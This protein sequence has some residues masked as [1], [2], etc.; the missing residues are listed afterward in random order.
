MSE[1]VVLVGP[2]ETG[3]GEAL[4]AEGFA[5]SRTEIGNRPGLEE[6]GIH[7]A[8]V[9][10]LTDVDQATSITVATD[11]NPDV[12]V[13]IYDSGSLPAFAT[14]LTDLMVDPELLSPA[15]VAEEL[16]GNGD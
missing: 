10:L 4:E 5:V 9:Y 8:S 12:R 16:A 6:A 11:L 13:V 15:T 2:D 3:L 14:R 7:E 1:T